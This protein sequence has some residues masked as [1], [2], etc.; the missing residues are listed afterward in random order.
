MTQSAPFPEALEELVSQLSYRP[1]W[2]FR[3]VEEDRGQGSMGL[4]LIITT[5]GYNSYHPERGE[6]YAVNHHMIVPAASYNRQSWQNWILEQLLLVERHEACEF[7]KIG[8]RRPYAP[9]HG[10]G[11]DPYLVFTHGEERDRRTMYTG[12]VLGEGR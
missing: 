1:G 4:T 12:E 6:S 11:N 7:L 10:P 3:L 5:L 8:G 9:H 2:R